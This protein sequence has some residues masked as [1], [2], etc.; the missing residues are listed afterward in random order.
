MRKLLLI[1]M[2]M[3]SPAVALGQAGDSELL[4]ARQLTN[5]QGLFFALAR[6]DVQ[7]M[8]TLRSQGANPNVRLSQLGL[9]AKDVFGDASPVMDQPFDLA[10]LPILHWA[11]F[12][13]NIEAVKVLLR[14]GALVNAADVYGATALH[15]AAWGGRH[16]I[17]KLLLNNGADCRSKD[18]KRRT[19]KDWAVMSSQSDMLILLDSRACRPVA[20]KDS[21]GDGVPDHQD[22]CPGTPKGAAVDERGCWV[23]AYANFFDFDKS[24]VK[25][26]YLPHLANA[27]EVIRNNPGMKVDIQ[28]HTDHIGT[29]EYNMRLGQRRAEAVK[30][31]LVG[32]GVNPNALFTSSMG[33]RRPA[34]DNRT[35]RGRALNRRV[36]IHV[37]EPGTSVAGTSAPVTSAAGTKESAGVMQPE[38]EDSFAPLPAPP[39][40]GKTRGMSPVIR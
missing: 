10:G 12:L 4:L 23:V 35:S 15:W 34:A 6:G 31:V 36:E 9:R 22:L 5:D 30:R 27:A 8:A 33:E 7:N 29:D 16:S 14:G 18:T 26:R 20:M 2:V 17:G 39:A 28:G 19:P 1:L 24:V 3:W 11:V 32:N 13:D 40:S 25:S 21:D 37:R 38:G